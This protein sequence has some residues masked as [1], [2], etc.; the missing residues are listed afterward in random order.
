MKHRHRKPPLSAEQKHINKMAR[1][2]KI[3]AAARFDSQ[4]TLVRAITVPKNIT[5]A[6][7]TAIFQGKT[8]K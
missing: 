1:L 5:V 3:A 8:N 2:Q 4:A 6:V 7:R